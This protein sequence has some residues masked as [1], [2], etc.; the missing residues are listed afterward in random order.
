LYEHGHHGKKKKAGVRRVFDFVNN[1][2]NFGFFNISERR[3]LVPL[4]G[5]YLTHSLLSNVKRDILLTS[6]PQRD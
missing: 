3:E 5:S 1:H 4:L 6:Y 2:H